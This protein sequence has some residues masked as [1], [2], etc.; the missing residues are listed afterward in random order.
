VP[1]ARLGSAPEIRIEGVPGEL[2][3]EAQLV[4]AEERLDTAGFDAL[5]HEY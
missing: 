5:L 2:H 4:L 3:D 1:S